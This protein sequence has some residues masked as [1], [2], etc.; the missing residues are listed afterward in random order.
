MGNMINLKAQIVGLGVNVQSIKAFVQ[1]NGLSFPILNDHNR[2][3]MESTHL[4]L[5]GKGIVC[6][7]W[8]YNTS[9]VEPNYQEIEL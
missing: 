8:N 4:L 7:K 3:Y 1:Q 2:D 6:Y 5:N 9:G